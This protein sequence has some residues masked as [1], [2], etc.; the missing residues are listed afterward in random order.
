MS[1][2]IGADM[3]QKVADTTLQIFGGAGYSKDEPIER[4]WRET[5][6]VRILDGT[7]EMM[8]R[9]VARELYRDADRRNAPVWAQQLGGPA[10]EDRIERSA[11]PEQWLP[12]GA[13]IARGRARDFRQADLTS[14][15]KC[16]AN[17]RSDI[18]HGAND[19]EK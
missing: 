8:R 12:L 6:V 17:L 1:K 11:R 4:I 19:I 3:V 15:R 13:A 14:D 5:R 7:S 16:A 10:N 2:L 9:V 18:R